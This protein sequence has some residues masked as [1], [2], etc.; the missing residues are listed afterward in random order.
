MTNEQR[1][2]DNLEKWKRN[3]ELAAKQL[4][5]LECKNIT[6]CQNENGELNLKDQ[7][8]TPN[9]FHSLVSPE[10]EA[11]QWFLALN[12]QNVFV[13]YVYGIGLGYYY[14]AIKQWLKEN[15]NRTVVFLEDNLEV[16]HHFLETE[17]ATDFLMNR[18]AKLYYFD[19]DSTI[20]TFSFIT[21]L[22]SLAP[23]SV[24]SLKFYAKSKAQKLSEVYARIAFFHDMRISVST[25]FLHLGDHLG[26]IGNFYK[27][28]LLLPNSKLI[29]QMANQFEGIPAI[30]CGAGPSL[31]K[32]IHFLRTLKDKALIMAG[33]T[34]MNVLNGAGIM[35]HFGVGIDPNPSH[36]NRLIS[37][38][39]FEVPF[40]YRQRMYNPALKAVHG[41][42][43]F[44][45][46]SGGYKISDWFEEKLGV[47]SSDRI[48]EGHNVV[49]FN[50]GIAKHLGCNPIIVVGVDL[51][52]S[53]DSSYAPG[54]VRHAIHDPKD[55]FITKY[56]HEELLVKDDIYGKPVHTL[57]K[58]VNESIWF[59]QFVETNPGIRLLN[60]TEGGIGFAKV[61]N[62]NLEDA[63][64]IYLKSDYDFAS[65][66]H[67]ILQN[68]SVSNELTIEKVIEAYNTFAKS[69]INCEEYCNKLL[70]AYPL[71]LKK[72]DTDESPPAAVNTAEIN[73]I[74][75]N[76]ENEDGYQFLLK[77]Y[78]ERYLEVFLPHFEHIDIDT[79]HQSEKDI[80]VKKVAFE[81]GLYTFLKKVARHNMGLIAKI[82]NKFI[83]DSQKAPS[84]PLKKTL[85]AKEKL[86]QQRELALKNDRYEYDNQQL[87]IYD[88]ELGLD[89]SIKCNC[90]EVKTTY[91][92]GA[93]KSLSYLSRGLLHGP[94]SF[95]SNSGQLLSKNWYVNGQLEGK[96]WYYYST[97]ELYAINR[98]KNGL[99]EGYQEFYYKNGLPKSILYYKNGALEGTITL[100]HPNGK[101][102]RE[103]EF[104]SGKK[105]GTE[106]F[107]NEEGLLIIEAHYEQ[108][109][110]VGIAREWNDQGT[111]LKEIT[112]KK[113]SDK[114]E[115]KTWDANGIP[116]RHEE[117]RN[118]DYFDKVT[119]QT[120]SLTD[121][122]QHMYQSLLSIAP[123]INIEKNE[124][125]TTSLE[126]DLLVLK[127]EMEKMSK[128]GQEMQMHIGHTG[129]NPKEAVWKTPETERLVRSQLDSVR[130]NLSKVVKETEESLNYMI[131]ILQDQQIKS[132]E[133]H[134]ISDSN[135]KQ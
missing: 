68:S 52:Y 23:F 20:L 76:F 100:Y 12:L 129:L 8:E 75:S 79:N 126:E 18:Q 29:S 40:F 6:I 119:I 58:W 80:W 38:T 31:G 2:L 106:Y 135:E 51:A 95:F 99:P 44:V 71:L 36:Y 62:M 57:W 91:D 48:E 130:D 124:Q 109:V 39:A 114:F 72:H 17:R 116:H 19:W 45:T 107:W 28:L 127:N 131:Q 54:L 78:K 85:A 81:I 97:G 27:N 113:D 82:L 34:A 5:T 77:D 132:S 43:I 56:A 49:N 14:D 90:T 33:G 122:I 9:Y 89:Y 24:A 83:E 13:L 93:L 128:Y 117:S 65:T 102:K 50:I 84:N 69:L 26:F 111:L 10:R 125:Y 73:A 103:I 15:P 4:E 16:I 66:I 121:S 21:S 98:N 35:P 118:K 134:K 53:N 133:N 96:G 101:I 94:A 120:T 25:E 123:A 105:N 37:N 88:S 74:I 47:S 64:K 55:A 86:L 60:C 7:E 30:I 59:T 112:Y 11:K 61:E 42:H 63:A 115:I 104:S 87:K 3:N 108:D 46:G 1:F 32:N 22:F 41:E 70:E 92:N 110:P 67:G